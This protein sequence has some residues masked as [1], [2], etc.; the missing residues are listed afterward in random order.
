MEEFAALSQFLGA[1]LHQ[2]W[3]DEADDLDGI[4]DIYLAS[5]PHETVAATRAEIEVF[6][7]RPMSK[8][9]RREIVVGRFHASYDPWLDGLTATE[10]LEH[11]AGRLAAREG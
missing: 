3:P 5:A 11:V 10:W 7:K 1:Y 4:V 6:L 2:D 8:H 9:D